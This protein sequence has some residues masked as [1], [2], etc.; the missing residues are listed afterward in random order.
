MLGIFNRTTTVNY[1]DSFDETLQEFG[2]SQYNNFAFRFFFAFDGCERGL[3]ERED[4]SALAGVF[5]RSVTLTFFYIQ[6]Q[7]VVSLGS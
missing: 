7:V 2:R 6:E 1:C 3:K 4:K 5:C